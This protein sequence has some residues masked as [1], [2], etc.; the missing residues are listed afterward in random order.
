MSR[1]DVIKSLLRSAATE[2]GS[3][4]DRLGIG[5]S[6]K[7][8]L[9]LAMARRLFIPD[10]RLTAAVARVPEVIAAM[11]STRGGRVRIDA[12]LCDG[13]ALLFCLLPASVTFAPHG[14]KEWSVSVEPSEAALDPRSG[15]IFAA[16]AGEV[17]T[18]LWGPFL[19]KQATRGKNAHAH[20]EVDHLIMD[21]RTLPEVRAAL[22]Q[23][24]TATGIDALAL[25]SIAAE[26]GGLRLLPAFTGLPL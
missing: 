25:Q 23:R 10:A 1:L 21:L 8:T 9:S 24:M 16:L 19:R 26:E 5:A 22:A 3:R 15:D 4:L 14:S 18:T 6:L 17:A 12:S 7:Q 20:R 11:V 13:S 2:A